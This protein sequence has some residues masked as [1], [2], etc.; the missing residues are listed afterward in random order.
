M[1]RVPS[2]YGDLQRRFLQVLMN[3][4]MVS[5]ED[6]FRLFCKMY[7]SEECKTFSIIFNDCMQSYRKV[8]NP[9]FRKCH[10][11]EVLTEELTST[12]SERQHY[13]VSNVLASFYA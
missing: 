2:N 6:A 11:T 3:R 8:S 9:I 7:Q 4:R 10:E 13:Y 12:C 1:L 5:Y